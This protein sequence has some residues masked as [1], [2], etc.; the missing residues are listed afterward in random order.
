MNWKKRGLWLISIASG[1]LLLGAWGLFGGEFEFIYSPSQAKIKNPEKTNLA[2]VQSGDDY[3]PETLELGRKMFY[4]ETFGNEVFFTD[5]LGAFDGPFTLAN[6]TKAV[7][8]LAG[9]GTTNLQVELAESFTVGDKTFQ[10]GELF[11]TGL[12]VPKGAFFPL[13]VK[14]KVA[15]GRLKA[16]ISCAFCHAA[17][18]KKTGDILQGVSNTDLNIGMILAMGTNTASYFSHTDIKSLQDYLTDPS[19]EIMDSKGKRVLLPDPEALEKAVDRQIAEW[20]RGS[21]DTTLDYKN[22][23]VQIPDTFTLGDHPYGWSG[24]GLIG[25]YQ[26]LSAAINNAHAQNTDATSQMEISG[27]VLGIDK[28]SYLGTL[29]QHAATP[30]YRYD[31]S[32]SEKP[33]E[34]MKRVDPTR[35]VIGLNELVPTP[36][37]PKISYVSS[38]SLFQGTP[39]Y[40]AWE[41]VNAVSAWM[42][43]NL[44]PEPEVKVTAKTAGREIFERAG[45]I[46]CHAGDYLTNN[47][48]VPVEEVGTEPTRAKGFFLSEKYFSE[49]SLWSKDTPV[50]VPPNVKPV[51]LRVTD[52]QRNQLMLAWGHSPTKGGYKVPSL[53]GLYWSAPYLHDGGVAVG[54]DLEK[55]IG[56]SETVQKG[57]EPNPFNS[58]R[59]MV[60]RRLRE[61]VV[62]ANR[63]AKDITPH[64]T[65]EG[66]AYWV[67]EE[68]GFTKEEQETMI[69]YLFSIQDPGEKPR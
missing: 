38:V 46:A 27:P 36:F 4:G 12:D 6:I 44:V 58:L 41:Q 31:P 9:K 33:S 52:D 63:K 67:D 30:R 29:L 13:G 45:C 54:R 25:P 16:G 56:V 34:F 62:E 18:D 42:N 35:D 22:N 53:L 50:P 8:A 39:G 28:E 69:Y 48:V 1:I 21:I 23:P 47:R 40:R 57:I 11:D 17:V 15:D 61:R 68:S 10:R 24:Q 2:Q 3:S 43:T 5:I 55:Q 65:G 19:R 32:T 60:D 20:P 59:A 49:P 26:G 51:P 64:V 14:I 66:H 7:M 37:Y